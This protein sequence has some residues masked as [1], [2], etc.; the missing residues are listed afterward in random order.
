MRALYA[1]APAKSGEPSNLVTLIEFKRASCEGGDVTAQTDD[2]RLRGIE[3]T[4]KELK[5]SIEQ[6]REL[7]QKSQQLL[8][9]H[10]RNQ[11]ED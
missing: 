7:A 11:R 4:Q 5:Q 8:D 6:S 9:R 3:A 2:A 10:R 1:T